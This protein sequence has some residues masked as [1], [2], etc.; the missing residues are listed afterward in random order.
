M[1]IV[2]T[3]GK[4]WTNVC[5]SKGATVKIAGTRKMLGTLPFSPHSPAQLYKQVAQLCKENNT[6]C[7]AQYTTCFCQ[8]ENKRFTVIDAR[9]AISG[10]GIQIDNVVV[11]LM[12]KKKIKND[13][14][15]QVE[16][17]VRVRVGYGHSCNQIVS[18][19]LDLA[20]EVV[21]ERIR[22]GKRYSLSTSEIQSLITSPKR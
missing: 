21:C 1:W 10:D 4:K 5:F 19:T 15:H 8:H 16:T 6:H 3:D 14:R 2:R 12:D 18:T 13:L 9:Y 20:C 7:V 22:C 11:V 17:V